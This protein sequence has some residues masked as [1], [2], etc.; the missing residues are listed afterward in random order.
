M[1]FE[2]RNSSA[3]IVTHCGVLEFTADEGI[4][5][6]PEWVCDQPISFFC[7]TDQPI[8]VTAS[9]VQLVIDR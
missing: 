3:E 9:D 1:V 7:L 5:H 8:L 4:I 2:L 6:M